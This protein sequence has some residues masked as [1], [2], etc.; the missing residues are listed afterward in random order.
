MEKT[1][2]PMELGL[3]TFLA[4]AVDVFRLMRLEHDARI[5]RLRLG[6]RVAVFNRGDP[7][8]DGVDAAQ[9][10]DVRY[11]VVVVHR[12]VHRHRP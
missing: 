1:I 8:G 11:L 3:D 10:F 4:A 7:R 9:V 6:G 2:P 12:H 5:D